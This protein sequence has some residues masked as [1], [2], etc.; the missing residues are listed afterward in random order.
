MR[1]R[2]RLC[3]GLLALVLAL[4]CGTF[5]ITVKDSRGKPVT[6]EGRIGGR[7]CLAAEIGKDGSI[8]IVIQQDASSDWAGIRAI[9]TLAE[10][11]IAAMVPG[12]SPKGAEFTGPSDIGGCQGIFVD[13]LDTGP[14][15]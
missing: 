7:G 4:G 8:N 2:R 6:I 9:P 1:E 15:E 14:E 11:A 10:V 5:A 3:I 12:A 13:E